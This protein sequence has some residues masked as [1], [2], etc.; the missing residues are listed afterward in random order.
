[1]IEDVG[2]TLVQVCRE[3]RGGILVFFPSYGLMD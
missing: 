2:A 1:M 3:V